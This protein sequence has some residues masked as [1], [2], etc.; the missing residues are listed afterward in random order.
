M[1]CQF[2]EGGKTNNVEKKLEAIALICYS[3]LIKYL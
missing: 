2:T 3:Y 1:Q